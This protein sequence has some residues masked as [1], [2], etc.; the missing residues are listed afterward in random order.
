MHGY[1]QERA[2]FLYVYY[3]VSLH[4]SLTKSVGGTQKIRTAA[5]NK[6]QCVAHDMFDF[7][8]MNEEIK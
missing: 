8:M 7:I 4:S 6:A 3:T 2:V 1:I 5:L